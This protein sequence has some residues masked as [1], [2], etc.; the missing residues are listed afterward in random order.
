MTF[1]DRGNVG[2]QYAITLYPERQKTGSEVDVGWG[3]WYIEMSVDL[4]D[5]G[6]SWI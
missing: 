6:F 2:R 3:T 4:E 5:S 1:L